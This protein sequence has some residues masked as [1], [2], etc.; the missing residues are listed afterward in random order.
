M[1]YNRPRMRITGFR[2]IACMAAVAFVSSA[3]ASI[4]FK[5]GGAY[6]LKTAALI[7]ISS[8]KKN[9]TLADGTA[10]RFNDVAGIESELFRGD[11]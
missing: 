6:V 4:E 10:I 3:G 8:V 5:S 9:L 1:W 2:L 11:I 7:R